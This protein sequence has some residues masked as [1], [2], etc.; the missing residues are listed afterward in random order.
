MTNDYWEFL[1]SEENII[2]EVSVWTMSHLDLVDQV[3]IENH[4]LQL[5]I[6][7]DHIIPRFQDYRGF[8][9][10]WQ[11]S[12]NS[13]VIGHWESS[14]YSL[15]IYSGTIEVLFE[16]LSPV[17]IDLDTHQLSVWVT[18]GSTGKSTLVKGLS[19]VNYS[20]IISKPETFPKFIQIGY[21][22]E[23]GIYNY[24]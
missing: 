2:R 18:D 22:H 9:W 6:I 17:T 3:D 15:E 10:A 14:K 24:T 7:P 5:R 8:L 21:L 4:W 1:T 23:K 12:K 20:R 11:K 16:N 13:R 19:P